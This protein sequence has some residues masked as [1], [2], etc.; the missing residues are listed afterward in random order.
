MECRICPGRHFADDTMF[1]NIASVLHCFDIGPPLDDRGEPVKIVPEWT[2]GL[3]SYVFTSSYVSSLV[4][5]V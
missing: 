5:Y 1:I 3:L 2:D 4:A